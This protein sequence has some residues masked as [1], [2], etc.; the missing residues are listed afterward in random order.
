MTH[1]QMQS[2]KTER[3]LFE[4][5]EMVAER[6]ESYI[7]GI[8]FFGRS[9]D[10]YNYSLDSNFLNRDQAYV[11]IHGPDFSVSVNKDISGDDRSGY[12]TQV[13]RGSMPENLTEIIEGL[14]PNKEEL[15]LA[16]Q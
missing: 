7:G 6:G 16:R 3:E 15:E 12:S 8:V 9:S 5:A 14:E 10:G 2:D 1:D 13:F 4:I 11:S